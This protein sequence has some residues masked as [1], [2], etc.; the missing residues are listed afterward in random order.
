MGRVWK[1]KSAE[2]RGCNAWGRVLTDE[3]R[4]LE[5]CDPGGIEDLPGETN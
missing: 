4:D 3:P 5:E 1:G 2:N